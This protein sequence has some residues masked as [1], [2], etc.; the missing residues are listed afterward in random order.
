[1]FSSLWR[2]RA[3]RHCGSA[4]KEFRSGNFLF[5]CS[6]CAQMR[7]SPHESH[8][9]KMVCRLRFQLGSLWLS[10]LLFLASKWQRLL[11]SFKAVGHFW[12]FSPSKRFR[13]KVFHHKTFVQMWKWS[14]D[15]FILLLRQTV[16]LLLFSLTFVSVLCCCCCCCS[17]CYCCWRCCCRYR[18]QI[19]RFANVNKK[20]FK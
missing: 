20:R 6:G 19:S 1:M 11:K 18:R 14:I 10:V 9:I 17:C 5:T 4:K 2:T 13:A 3:L 7:I 15:L 8:T 16:F 12:L